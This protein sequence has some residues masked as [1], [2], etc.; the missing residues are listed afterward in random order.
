MN[1]PTQAVCPAC[2]AVNRLDPDRLGQGPVCGK[3]AKPLL[4]GEVMEVDGA[5]LEQFINRSGLPLL[6]DFFAPWCG[7][8]R[9]MSPQLAEAARQL[10]PAVITLKVDTE[11]NPSAGSRHRI[12]SVPTLGLFAA[13]REVDRVSGAMNAQDIASWAR[14]RL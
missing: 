4:P 14:S 5:S 7:P 3:C 6:V 9:M 2:R 8:C 13:S 12:Q 1:Q 11:Q 10:A